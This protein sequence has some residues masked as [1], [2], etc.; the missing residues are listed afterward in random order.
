MNPLIKQF[1]KE[2][3]WVLWKLQER[4]G[5]KTKVPYSIAGDLA[6][7]TDPDT[8]STYEEVKNFGDNIGIVFTPEQN[9]LGIDIDHC[10]KDNKI[11]HE[12]KESI[13]KLIDEAST[14]TEISPSG[15]GLHL[16]LRITEA[17]KLEANK[18]AP[19]E[20]YTSGRYFT[21]TEKPFGEIKDVREVTPA[22]AI[23]LLQ[24]IGYPWNKEK[25]VNK[26]APFVD[27]EDV[28]VNKIVNPI[29]NLTDSEVLEKMFGAKNGKKARD[30][31]EMTKGKSE[32]DLAFCSHLAFWTRKDEAQMERIWLTSPLGSR[33]KTQ[34]RKDYRDRTIQTAI[35]SCKQVYELS[36]G[37]KS[38]KLAEKLDIDFLFSY[39]QNGKKQ[40][41]MNTENMCRIF[42]V[43]PDFNKRFR[44][45]AFKNTLEILKKGKWKIFE[46]NDAVDVQSE[47][48]IL[49]SYFARVSKTMVWDAMVKVAVENSIDTA[50]DYVQSLT[51]DGKNRLNDWLSSVYGAPSNAYN[52][53]V[54]SN[55]LKGLVKRIV[56]PG[57]KFDYVL[58]LEGPQ[59]SKKSTSLSILAGG[60]HVETTMSTDTKD[61]F[62]QFVG[63]LIIEFSE[64]DT[65]NRTE[66]KRM[67]AIITTQ[68]DKYRPAYGRSIQEFPRRCVFAMTTN[69]EEYL[70]DETGNRRWLPVRLTLPEANI[71]WLKAN[72][73]QLFAETYH[74]VVKLEETVYEFPNQDVLEEQNARRV[75]YEHEDEIV[76]WYDSL[77]DEKK[78]Y[79]ITVQ[80]VYRDAMNG[81]FSSKMLNKSDEMRISDVLKNVLR[82]DKKRARVNSVRLWRWYHP[83]I[84]EI[85]EI[86]ASEIQ[87]DF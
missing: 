82:L 23:T 11:V 64:G 26:T 25:D 76:F 66:V 69:D 86:P 74:R 17:F 14:Y 61:F 32:D 2:S 24:T 40:V 4:K 81:S 58:V 42:R 54:G 45:D 21:F 38:K 41:V 68:V 13:E 49:F 18:Q 72:R 35:K 83:L 33:K 87:E 70:R 12:Q 53:A 29:V 6:S 51:W 34:S 50:L 1:G 15:T 16:F 7:S 79:G 48:A 3:R 20:L 65:L 22:A 85:E 47:V 31:Y 30:L 73:D 59:G 75:H 46:D 44:Y 8:W 77:S 80:Q 10:L 9:L 60:Y 36:P 39:D 43:H 5:K 28:N 55:W 62:M 19:F 57:A 71:E 67:K 63:N 84:K 52:K 78:G 27:N 37:L 56:E